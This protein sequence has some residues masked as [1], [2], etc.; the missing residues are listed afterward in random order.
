[1]AAAGCA[2][3]VGV[4][5]VPTPDIGR[6]NLCD[7]QRWLPTNPTASM[8]N[9]RPVVSWRLLH[10]ARCRKLGTGRQPPGILSGFWAGGGPGVE[11]PDQSFGVPE[12]Q[13]GGWPRSP[14]GRSARPLWQP[15]GRGAGS[16]ANQ[17]PQPQGWPAVTNTAAQGAVVCGLA[18]QARQLI[19]LTTCGIDNAVAP[20]AFTAEDS[21]PVAIPDQLPA[22]TTKTTT[23]AITTDSSP[24]NRAKRMLT[25]TNSPP[26]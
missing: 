11:W 15:R 25:T 19:F 14:P 4:C 13:A 18:T 9:P 24:R 5:F 23:A 2:C 22:S 26:S 10:C 3:L 21:A 8:R 1:M 6:I 20:L 16:C 7:Y 17:S 12:S